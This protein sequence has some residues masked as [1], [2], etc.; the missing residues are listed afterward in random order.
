MGLTAMN[1]AV[2][3]RIEIGDDGTTEP[4]PS[5]LYGALLDPTLRAAAH[6]YG[7]AVTGLVRENRATPIK[8][9]AKCVPS[10]AARVVRRV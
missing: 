2:F 6:A 1:Q 7:N 4:V 10:F 8:E 5:Q 9:P 3:S